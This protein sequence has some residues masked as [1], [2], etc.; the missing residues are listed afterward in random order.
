MHNFLLG[1][2]RF[3]H[4]LFIIFIILVPFLNNNYLLLLHFITVP[5]LIL[6]WICGNN[7]CILTIIEKK[8][9]QNINEKYDENDCFTC[10][11]IEPVYNFNKNYEHMSKFTYIITII[12]WMVTSGKLLYKYKIGEITSFGDLYKI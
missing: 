9:R 8:I 11:L 3:L 12:L 5:F 1:F 2:I 6:H 4:I 7:T 10:R